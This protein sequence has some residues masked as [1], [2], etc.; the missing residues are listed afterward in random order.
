MWWRWICHLIER[1]AN[2][3]H[4]MRALRRHAEH[5]RQQTAHAFAAWQRSWSSDP[6]GSRRRSTAARCFALARRRSIGAAITAWQRRAFYGMQSGMGKLWSV[7]RRETRIVEASLVSSRARISCARRSPICLRARHTA[8]DL[9]PPSRHPPPVALSSPLPPLS[10]LVGA[11]APTGFLASDGALSAPR[12]QAALPRSSNRI[13]MAPTG[14]A[15]RT[16]MH[17]PCRAPRP[18]PGPRG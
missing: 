14:H 4:Q 15:R 16:T 12:P 1:R 6:F 13:G 8:H 7:R 11:T 18:A 9:I 5:E 3:D 10:L 17:G 2:L